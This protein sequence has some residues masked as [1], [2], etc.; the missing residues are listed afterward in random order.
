MSETDLKGALQRELEL[1][2]KARD[3]LKL[4]IHL[5]KGEAREE[6]KRLETLWQRVESEL[7]RTSAHAKEPVKELGNAARSIVDELKRGYARVKA[8]LSQSK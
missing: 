3:E 1:L 7:M 2:R 4:Q 6:W 5:G 8:E